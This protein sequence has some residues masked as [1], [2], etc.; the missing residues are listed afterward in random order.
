MRLA[1]RRNR[2]RGV[3]RKLERRE[4]IV[5]AVPGKQSMDG[6]CKALSSPA[7]P[8]SARQWAAAALCSC[9]ADRTGKA[10]ALEPITP[11]P[12]KKAYPCGEPEER[13]C[14]F[15]GNVYQSGVAIT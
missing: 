10:E 15:G 9:S 2:S 12:F 14:D 8:A 5:S 6:G 1:H 4:E 13:S 3:R 7:R 11:R